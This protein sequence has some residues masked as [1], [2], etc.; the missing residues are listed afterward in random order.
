MESLHASAD[1]DWVRFKAKADNQYSIQ[2]DISENSLA[3]AALEV[4]PECDSLEWEEKQNLSF[5][6]GIKLTFK[7]PSDGFFYRWK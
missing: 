4:Y 2:V 7:A 6:P 3:D 1:N 5:S